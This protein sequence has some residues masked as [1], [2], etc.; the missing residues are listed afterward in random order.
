LACATGAD[1]CADAAILALNVAVLAPLKHANYE[2]YSWLAIK[3]DLGFGGVNR[4]Q[5]NY[6]RHG[7]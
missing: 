6:D 4:F 3:F 7:H 2:I 1:R 5:L